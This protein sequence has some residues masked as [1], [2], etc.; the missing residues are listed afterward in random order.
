M[1]RKARILVANYPHHIVQRGHNRKVV[2]LANDDYRFYLEN[3]TEWK[4]K[5]SVKLYAWC[6]MTNHVHLIVEPGDDAEVVSELMKRVAGRQAAF[7][8]KQEGRSGALWGG[9][10][11]A[12]PI[13]KDNYL[14]ACNR[15]VEMNP[16]RAN[17]VAGPRQYRWS[18]YRERIGCSNDGLLD[19]DA[20]YLGL[21]DNVNERIERYKMYLK[22][23]ASDKEI[24]MLR[25]AW[26]R[27]QLTG[28]NRFIDEVEV[29]L[30][31]R[32]EYRS[33][34]RPAKE[35]KI[36]TCPFSKEKKGK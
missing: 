9:R 35:R 4:N 33:R 26:Q 10:F 14:L 28:N 27:N 6:L 25:N 17:M 15:Y 22:Q 24:E 36:V 11:K 20:S 8:N 21:A 18:S 12:S 3:L 29:R 13:Q 5:L 19:L 2:F 16:V 34:G 23:G 30:G 31:R 1:P 7:V 32:V